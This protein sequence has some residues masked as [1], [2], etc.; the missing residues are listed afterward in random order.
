MQRVLAQS[1]WHLLVR[2]VAAF[3]FGVLALLWPGATLYF[4]IA[5]FAAYALIS[6][7]ASLASALRHR[8]EGGWWLLLL[9]SLVSLAAGIVAIVYPGLTALALVVVMGVNAAV[10][11]VL[12]IA[13][14]IRLRREIAGEWLLGL[15]GVV[16]IAFGALVLIFPGAGALA[17]VWLI[18]VYAIAVGILLMVLGLRLHAAKPRSFHYTT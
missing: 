11:G 2:G 13:M 18:A 5:V 8:E 12:D 16:S 1:W 6:G 3:A 10:S 4:L 14:A 15:A 7:A 17:L 9:F